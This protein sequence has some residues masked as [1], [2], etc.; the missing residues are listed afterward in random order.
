MSKCMRPIVS[1]FIQLSYVDHTHMFREI[2]QSVCVLL[3][4]SLY[5]YLMLTIHTCLG[6]Y[7]KVYASYC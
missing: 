1:V 4:A 2:C 5:S 7:V 3:L 6:K